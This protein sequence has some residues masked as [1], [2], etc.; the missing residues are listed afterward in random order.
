MKWRIYY[1]DGTTF[2]STMGEP[3]DAPCWGVAA[4]SQVDP[5]SGRAGVAGVDNYWWESDIQC[6]SGGDDT[7][8]RDQFH[9]FPRTRT[10]WKSARTLA[11]HMDW[12]K[13]QEKVITDPDLPPLT[14]PFRA[15]YVTPAKMRGVWST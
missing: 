3:E 2:D 4:I 7:G 15:A 8:V 14:R 11:R 6:W 10:A 13:L 5:D 9:H 12:R 1:T